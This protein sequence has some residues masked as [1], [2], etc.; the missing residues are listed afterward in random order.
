MKHKN[1]NFG[2]QGVSEMVLDFKMQRKLN[3]GFF[4]FFFFFLLYLHVCVDS[5]IHFDW[6]LL[7][8]LTVLFALIE[9]LLI[10]TRKLRST[11]L[12]SIMHPL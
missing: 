12:D 3:R 4:F 2:F 9:V 8:K 5:H 10:F 6:K 11:V 7:S 1:K